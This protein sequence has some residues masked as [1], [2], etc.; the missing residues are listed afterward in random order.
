MEALYNAIKL[1]A[2][3]DYMAANDANVVDALNAKTIQ[4]IDSEL[5]TARWLIINRSPEEAGLV[6]AT[7]KT[8]GEQNP[9]V[10]AAYHS[11]N[12]SGLDLSHAVTQ[13]FIDQLAVVGNW[14][15]ELTTWLKEKGVWYTS[16]ADEI[17]GRDATLQDVADVRTWEAETDYERTAQLSIVVNPNGKI[18]LSCRVVE[19]TLNNKIGDTLSV[20]TTADAANANLPARLQTIVTNLTQ[21]ISEV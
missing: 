17:L 2:N 18:I 21:Y 6:L 13:S 4:H 15:A 9:I 7:M 10:E 5:R 19:S 1:I 12:S 8:V 16:Q 11:L 14:P 3:A 20:V